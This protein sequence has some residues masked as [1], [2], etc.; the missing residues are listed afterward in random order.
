ML[1]AVVPDVLDA[2]VPFYGTPAARELRKNIK[3]PL[4]IHLA[5][6]NVAR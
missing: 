6:S 3:T 2:G 4:L 5:G 1:S